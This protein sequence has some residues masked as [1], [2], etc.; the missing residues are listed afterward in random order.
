MIIS[1]LCTEYNEVGG[2]IQPQRT[3]K[4]SESLTCDK[5][6]KSTQS[7]KCKKYALDLHQNFISLNYQI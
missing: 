6:Y 3:S 2:L 1:G 4:C 7:Y 5:I